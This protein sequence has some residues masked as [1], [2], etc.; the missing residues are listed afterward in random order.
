MSKGIFPQFSEISF[1][2][3]FFCAT[4]LSLFNSQQYISVSQGFF[5]VTFTFALFI[6]SVGVVRASSVQCQ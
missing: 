6:A 5:A 2:F 4:M 1:A 3:K